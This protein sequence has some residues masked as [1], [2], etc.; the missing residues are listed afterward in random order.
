MGCTDKAGCERLLAEMKMNWSVENGRAADIRLRIFRIRDALFEAGRQIVGAEGLAPSEFSI[1]YVLRSQVP[2]HEMTPGALSEETQL[3]SGGVTKALDALERHGLV[4][5]TLS[6]TD[7]RSRIVR[8]TTDGIGMV[9][10]LMDRVLARH[11]EQIS[12]AL[13]ESEIRQFIGLLQ[14]LVNGL[15]G[16]RYA[17]AS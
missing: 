11:A 3:T 15:E 13:S 10:S 12:S 7:R 9:E 17:R 1:L 5:R 4:T 6:E 8:L 14:K 16:V 2:P